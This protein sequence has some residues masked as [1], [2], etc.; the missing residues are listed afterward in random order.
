[1]SIVQGKEAE[2]L[3][4]E[5]MTMTLEKIVENPNEKDVYLDA[6]QMILDNEF[7]GIPDNL[8]KTLSQ[9]LLMKERILVFN[10]SKKEE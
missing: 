2:D 8:K 5:M 4:N 10:K 9:Y 3:L 7:S 6:F 1:M